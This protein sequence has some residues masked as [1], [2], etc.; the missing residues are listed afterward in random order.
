LNGGLAYLSFF[1]LFFFFFFSFSAVTSSPFF[2][3]A[4]SSSPFFFL[5]C[6]LSTTDDVARLRADEAVEGGGD[7]WR[8]SPLRVVDFEARVEGI[9]LRWVG[10]GLSM[11]VVTVGN[12]AVSRKGLH[13]CSAS[14]GVCKCI[15]RGSVLVIATHTNLSCAVRS[16]R[17]TKY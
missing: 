5:T 17:E 10:D 6:V 16:Y 14:D 11:V 3:S 1:P 15:R 4:V 9:S 8:R 7:A 12:G 2:C 13:P